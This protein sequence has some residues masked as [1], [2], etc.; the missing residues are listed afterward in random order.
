MLLWGLE[1]APLNRSYNMIKIIFLICL[2]PLFSFAG[3]ERIIDAHI[4]RHHG[5]DLTLPEVP[6]PDTLVS[7]DLGQTLSNKTFNA[8]NMLGDLNLNWTSLVPNPGHPPILVQHYQ[9]IVGLGDA[10]DDHDATSKF[11]VDNKHNWQKLDLSI[12][13]DMIDTGS[14]DVGVAIRPNSM[15]I[16]LNGQML[17]EVTQYTITGSVI[18]FDSSVTSND[19][20]WA[21]GLNIFMKFQEN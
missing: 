2:F 20:I 9:R 18:T 5:Q 15:D 17:K 3:A 21:L 11:Y 8:T 10:V 13:Q 1:K 4:I 14:F 6:G 12:T 7:T 16:Y 19:M